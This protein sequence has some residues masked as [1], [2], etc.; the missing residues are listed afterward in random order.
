MF[1]PALAESEGLPF[2]ATANIREIAGL[3]LVP[4]QREYFTGFQ[5]IA[6]LEPELFHHPPVHF[7]DIPVFVKA[8]F[9]TV[10]TLRVG[11]LDANHVAGVHYLDL[12]VR[13]LFHHALDLVEILDEI[14]RIAY[15]LEAQEA[16]QVMCPERYSPEFLR[17]VRSPHST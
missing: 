10:E 8:T 15:P 17:L 11:A 13:V 4:D 7:F 5:A 1:Q 12:E 14:R 16:Q 3:Y 6:G 2:A 9:V